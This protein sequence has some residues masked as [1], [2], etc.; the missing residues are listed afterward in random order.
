MISETADKVLAYLQER[1]S[2][3]RN[4]D[5]RGFT[6]DGICAAVDEERKFVEKALAELRSDE[7]VRVGHVNVKVFVP[8]TEQG[9]R[10]LKR[11]AHSGLISASPFLATLLAIGAMIAVV[12]MMP[13]EVADAA[14]A[15]HAYRNGFIS[16][17][18]TT[19]LFGLFGAMVIHAGLRR[20]YRLHAA[21][22]E[23]FTFVVRSLQ[24]AAAG[25]ILAVGAYYVGAEAL[26]YVF[27]QGVAVAVGSIG[28]ATAIGVQQMALARA[29]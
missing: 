1:A 24:F 11:F 26:G 18:V 2:K 17:L 28:A 13:I 9:R 8:D 3:G 6:E 29:T 25:L 22:S 21:S 10:V 12:K 5:V 20:F 4:L 19:A 16:G 23:T 15:P 7:L 14:T 27:H